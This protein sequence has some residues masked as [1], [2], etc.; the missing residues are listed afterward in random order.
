M[1][2]W[3][4]ARC[5]RLLRPLKTHISA[6]RREV[7]LDN[8]ER[9]IDNADQDS[10][11]RGRIQHTYS[12]RGRKAQHP[13]QPD[14]LKRSDTAKR[15]TKRMVRSKTIQPGEIVLPT[16]IIRRA[17][18]LQLS[19]PL[20][21]PQITE[22]G[23][24][25]NGK[26]R[27]ATL[28]GHRSSSVIA[29]LESEMQSLRT[30][31]TPNK[32][33]LYD[34]VLRALHSL[35]TATAEPAPR[36]IGSRSLIAM[37]L[38]KVPDYIGELEYWEQREA[39]E[40]GTKSALQ[41]SEV[42]GQVY[43]ELQD[44]FPTTHGSTHLRAVVRAHGVK[45]IR[46]SIA[47]GLFDDGFSIL[48]TKLCCKTKSYQEGE[49]ILQELVDRSYPKPKGVDSY[50]DES[51]KLAPLKALRD[52]SKESNRPQFMMREL[53]KLLSHQLLP[54]HWLSTNEFGS[55]WSSMVKGLST[56]GSCDDTL[57]FA[58]QVITSLSIQARSGT[59]S[60]RPHIGDL[61]ALSQQTLLSAV[62]S[63]ATLPILSQEA[64]G[65]SVHYTSQKRASTVSGRAEYIIQTCI[66][67]MRR[68]RKSSW[69][70]P[71]LKLA[72]YLMGP[73]H[74]STKGADISEVWYRLKTDQKSAGGK[75]E[76][77]A[78]T[79]LI[80]SIA[81]C[82]S[83]GTSRPPHHYLIELC[84]QLDQGLPVEGPSRKIRADCA[85]FLAE[86]TN[87][88]RD[89]A[90]AESLDPAGIQHSIPPTPRR[91]SE[92]SSYPE[93][94]W[95]EDICE[96]VT[97]TP[98]PKRLSRKSSPSPPG[99]P[100]SDPDDEICEGSVAVAKKP[101]VSTSRYSGKESEEDSARHVS[102]KLR[103]KRTGAAS[104]TV[105]R[106]D[107]VRETGGGRR[108]TRR[109]KRSLE[110]SGLLSLVDDDDEGLETPHSRR[111]S[112]RGDEE[113]DRPALCSDGTKKRRITFLK[114][115][116]SVLRTIADAT[117]DDCSDD[118]L[119]L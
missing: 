19:S 85:F 119:G 77:E 51:R 76:Y 63:I 54:L 9:L 75:Q 116:R 65:T 16:P 98:A 110:A 97:A 49:E 101:H 10:A 58:V 42:S 56:E 28:N 99:V 70:S 1:Q 102:S 8:S 39:E 32:F 4:T 103:Q 84:D 109:S 89:L 36:L 108:V 15:T 13:T 67:E 95:E 72:A 30:R 26:K 59:F 33:S 86:R 45:V 3:T 113:K 61:K 100:S 24:T 44:M 35:L 106:S 111:Q 6:L 7:D 52:F 81:Q 38:R 21:Q 83:R 92:S 18:G 25:V 71:I 74:N 66:Y 17:R 46:D 60:L 112:S 48:L 5:H 20:Q 117:H 104:C 96:W 82:C 105:E 64:S 78:A 114:P 43:D 40:Q 69:I 68:T 50:F 94:R 80:G 41:S 107:L 27:L 90:F 118:E 2:P 47:E 11:A 73:A 57:S 62:T 23:V 34:A 88:L 79:A 55:V 22:S 53:S 31:V 12:R 29:A 87:D 115:P 14:S 91:V 93:Y 37:C